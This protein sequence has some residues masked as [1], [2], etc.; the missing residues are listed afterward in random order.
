MEEH[1]PE[2]Q[3]TSIKK[4]P[5]EH[6][7]TSTAEPA[8]KAHSPEQH[9]I[10]AEEAYSPK[11]HQIPT[12]EPSPEKIATAE[13]HKKQKIDSDYKTD[14]TITQ[15]IKS[16]IDNIKSFF[17]TGNVVLKI[18]MIIIFFGV[19]F[20]LKYAAQRNLFP[21]ELRLVSVVAAGIAM[22][23]AGWSMRNKISGTKSTISGTKST[24]AG[25]RVEIAETEKI[26]ARLQYGLVLQG[27]GIG[28]LYLTIF[29]ASKLYHLMPHTLS[30]F[31]M[32]MLVALSGALAVMQDAK[33]LAITGIIGGFLAPVLMSTGSGSHVMLFSYYALLNCGVLGIAWFKAWRELNLIGFAFTFII[34]ALWGSKYYKPDF[35]PTTEPFL[36]L[37]FLFYVTISI[38]FAHRQPLKLKGFIDGPLV[39]GVPLVCFGLQS[40]L[41]SHME[42]GIAIT[43]LTLGLFYIV[44]ATVLWNRLVEGMRML[45]EAFIAM[46]VVFGSLAIPLAL[47]GKWTSTAWALEGGAMVWVGV[48]QNRLLARLFGMLLQFG[49]GIAFLSATNYHYEYLN[50]HNYFFSN[51]YSGA[52]SH[53]MLFINHF[54]LGCVFIS[55]AGLFSSYYLFS[56]SEKLRNWEHYFHIPL[57]IWG[58]FWWFGGGFHEIKDQFSNQ[59]KYH[60]YLQKIKDHAYLLYCAL[61][62]QVMSMIA[63][64]FRW[65][66]LTYSMMGFLPVML[67]IIALELIDIYGAFFNLYA[68]SHLFANWGGVVWITAF[69]VQYGL[70][71]QFDKQLE[72]HGDRQI[73]NDIDHQL[74]GKNH[75]SDDNHLSGDNRLKSKMIAEKYIMVIPELIIRLIPWWHIITMWMLIFILSHETV[76]T[77]RQFVSPVNDSIIWSRIFWGIVPAFFI[78][79][80]IQKSELLKWPV[81]KHASHYLN[82]GVT[83]PAF[84]MILWI[85][86]SNFYHGNPVPLPYIPLVNPLELSQIFVLIVLSVRTFLQK[87]AVELS[88]SQLPVLF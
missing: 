71:W 27:G 74:S 62:C 36:I 22:L 44:L 64:R 28:I 49:A 15:S 9:Q 63:I 55:I 35:F 80:L 73:D 7:Y 4:H 37:F 77:V 76:W 65:R 43:A 31:I 47:D 24:I 70:L 67:C 6:H 83:L 32:I 13:E 38:L 72:K 23:V 61:S 29:A 3:H 16:F 41:V 25:N 81:K 87:P 60:A 75:L 52:T 84:F 21:I 88:R 53:S 68:T 57:L 19:S 5:P 58:L 51:Y 56:N 59:Y 2:D 79:L 45:T 30:L 85:L 33:S 34:S 48:R 18:G 14:R 12:E 66:Q 86:R 54:Y 46:C 50:F 17:T 82:Q 26:P 20:L 78:L 8:E 1:K 69:A 11:Q 39:F 10:P 42:Y 40:S